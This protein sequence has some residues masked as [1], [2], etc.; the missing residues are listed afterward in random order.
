MTSGVSPSESWGLAH[1]AEPAI[2]GTGPD[3]EFRQTFLVGHQATFAV[4]MTRSS[5]WSSPGG[6]ARRYSGGPP[7]PEWRALTRRCSTRGVARRRDV[8]RLL[9]NEGAVRGCARSAIGRLM[10]EAPIEAPI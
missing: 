7:G 2:P 3:S 10:I 1:T 8:F 6:C 5:L 4:L 9:Q